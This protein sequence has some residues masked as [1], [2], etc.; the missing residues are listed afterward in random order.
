M[1]AETKRLRVKEEKLDRSEPER[2][3]K[4]NQTRIGWV[5]KNVENIVY[6]E[7]PIPLAVPTSAGMLMD[8]IK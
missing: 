1:K 7:E 3:E 8:M 6:R 5:P 4:D 2:G